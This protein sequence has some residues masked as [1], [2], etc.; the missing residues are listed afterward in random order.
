MD[1][2]RLNTL[3]P[4]YWTSIRLGNHEDLANT[5]GLLLLKHLKTSPDAF[6]DF[7]KTSK[8]DFEKAGTMSWNDFM[9]RSGLMGYLEEGYLND[10]LDVTSPRPAIGRGEFLFTSCFSNIGFSSGRGDLVDMDTGKL[11]EVK[12]KRATISGDGKKYKMMSGTTIATAFSVYDTGSEAAYFNR[13]GA[14]H[15]ESC[16]AED[17]SETKLVEFLKRMQNIKNES[18]S[19]AKAFAKLYNGVKPNLFDIVGAMQ[20]YIYLKGIDY[21]LMIN[22]MGFRCF[23]LDENPST[24]INMIGDGK[25]KL[26]SWETGERGME[27]SI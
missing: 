1:F 24:Y 6:F 18:Y 10:A 8:F 27:I 7:L 13:S 26:S 21:L 19:V 3:L 11:V 4:E 16:I 9:V 23:K 2:N 20:L 14:N 12:G 15:I 25:L 5:H 22:D 17:D